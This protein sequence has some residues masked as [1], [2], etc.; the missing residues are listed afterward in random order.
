MTDE[1][2]SLEGYSSLEAW[3]LLAALDT[4]GLEG[5]TVRPGAKK[6]RQSPDIH[7]EGLKLWESRAVE[8]TRHDNDYCSIDAHMFAECAL[9]VKD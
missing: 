5:K 3:L 2:S 8:F 1:P 4:K 9:V 7:H 6:V